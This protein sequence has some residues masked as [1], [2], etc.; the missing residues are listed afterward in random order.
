MS[1]SSATRRPGPQPGGHQGCFG[2]FNGGLSFATLRPLSIIYRP[3]LVRAIP[4]CLQV[5]WPRKKLTTD[6][7]RSS[8]L[9]CRGTGRGITGQTHAARLK[10]NSRAAAWLAGAEADSARHETCG[11]PGGTSVHSSGTQQWPVS[12]LCVLP[13]KT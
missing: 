1:F 11:F 2:A 8:C 6:R 10:R 13:R 3:W 9:G 12:S 5:A 7:S 4:R